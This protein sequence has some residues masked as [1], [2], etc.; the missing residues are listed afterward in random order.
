MTHFEKLL[1]W[2]GGNLWG[3]LPILMFLLFGIFVAVIAAVFFWYWPVLFWFY[4]ILFYSILFYFILFY[5]S[6]VSISVLVWL[7]FLGFWGNQHKFFELKEELCNWQEPL[8]VEKNF[9]FAVTL[10]LVNNHQKEIL[11][12]QAH[13]FQCIVLI[14]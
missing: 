13:F 11:N 6:L 5:S 3:D 7:Q 2:S 10:F 8:D 1:F 12:Y 14:V 9:L 4:S